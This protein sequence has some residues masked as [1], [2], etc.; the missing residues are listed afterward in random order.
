MLT[1]QLDLGT[2][3]SVLAALANPHNAQHLANTAAE[4]YTDSILDWIAAGRGFT[5]RTGG[6]L[7]QSIGWRGL[8]NGAAEVYVNKDYAA[9]VEQGTGEFV[10]HSSWVI[11]PRAGR[12]A[13]YFGGRFYRSVTHHGSRPHPFFFADQSS[14]GDQMQ[15]KTLSVLAGIIAHG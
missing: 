2:T 8:G 5:P 3:P 4:S 6:G 1:I 13:L 7:E 14:R 15:E 11:R 10:G 9:Y 12:S